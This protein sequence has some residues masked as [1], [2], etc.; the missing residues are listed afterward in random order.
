M[1]FCKQ[2]RAHVVAHTKPMDFLHLSTLKQCNI[3]ISP[4]K[5]ETMT[6]KQQSIKYQVMMAFHTQTRAQF[7]SH[8]KAMVFLHLS[9]LK[10]C[11]IYVSPLKHGC[12]FF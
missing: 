1:T 10:Q 6:K 8:T 3:D 4:L 7:V 2:T 5:Y 9:T 11:N 12:G